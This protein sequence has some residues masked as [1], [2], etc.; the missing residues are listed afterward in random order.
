MRSEYK[1]QLGPHVTKC[2]LTQLSRWVVA[3]RKKKQDTGEALFRDNAAVNVSYATEAQS[4]QEGLSP[5]DLVK[6]KDFLHFVI[7]TSR[8]SINDRQKKVTVDSM[9]TFAEWFFAR[10]ARVTGSRIDEKDRC[11][12]Y[13]VSAC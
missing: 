4:L 11:A 9:N 12:V 10:F 13:D 7:A 5:L 3:V 2:V 1:H 6:I 8:G